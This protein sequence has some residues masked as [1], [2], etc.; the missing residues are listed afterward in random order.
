MRRAWAERRPWLEVSNQI[1]A[2]VA[3]GDVDRAS[4]LYHEYAAGRSAEVTNGPVTRW[5]ETVE[6]YDDGRRVSTRTNPTNGTVR[7]ETTF[8][9]GRK[10]IDYRGE[11]GRGHSI[12]IPASARP[13]YEGGHYHSGYSH[14][15]TSDLD[16]D[17]TAIAF[18]N[19]IRNSLR[20]GR[21][22]K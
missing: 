13:D 11:N 22:R 9:D 7:T 5:P 16:D 6:E 19:Q 10:E 14:A 21:G 17:A 8:P 3:D 4:E 1:I 12:K 15:D 2:A 20:K 18:S